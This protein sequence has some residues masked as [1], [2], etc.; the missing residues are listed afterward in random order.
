MET[1]YGLKFDLA[2]GM[3]ETWSDYDKAVAQC[4]LDNYGVVIIDGSGSPI[5]NE[6][7]LEEISKL[8]R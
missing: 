2:H 3:H 8:I 1:F 4:H 6:F 5:D 7:D